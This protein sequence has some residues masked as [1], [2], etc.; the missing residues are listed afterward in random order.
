V[1]VALT[2]AMTSLGALGFLV[3]AVLLLPEGVKGADATG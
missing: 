1:N 3:G 2:N